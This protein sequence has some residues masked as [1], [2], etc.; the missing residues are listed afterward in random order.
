MIFYK[1]AIE[2]F[3]CLSARKA[4]S[5]YYLL[6]QIINCDDNLKIIF[7]NKILPGFYN[8][9]LDVGDNYYNAI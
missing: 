2:F 6:Q 8:L 9:T 3:T 5:Q 7:E 1:I 4:C